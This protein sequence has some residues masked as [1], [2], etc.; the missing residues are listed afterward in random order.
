VRYGIALPNY[1]ALATPAHVIRIAQHAE[2]AGLDSV[3]VSDHIIVPNTVASVYP[4]DRAVAPRA[5]NLRNL[6]RFYDA[7]TTLAFVAGTTA[8]VRLG[9]SAY[10]LP[11][12]N[13]IVTAKTVATL[14]ALSGGRVIFAVGTGWLA[15]EFEVLQV[16]FA[17]R[18]AR[19]D[20]YIRLCK[21]CWTEED[22]RFDSP[23]YHTDAFRCAPKP[24]QQ[25]LP[26]WIGGNG[27][28]AL[29]RA[30][31]FG[32][33]WHPIDLDPV[34]IADKIVALRRLCDVA[35]RDPGAMTISLRASITAAERSAEYEA[36]GVSHLVLNPR[37]SGVIDDVLEDIDQIARLAH[38]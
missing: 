28:R 25:P 34:E 36:V 18:G 22:I 16:P 26:I 17:D 33:G 1:G 20:E 19:T 8:R 21:A 11:I 13:P 5:A 2:A 7:L 35:G 4:Y 30:A 14:D 23:F 31:R 29:Q 32:D 24:V 9:V 38:P 3:W 27:Q 12:R 15:E 6:E 10:V 37:R